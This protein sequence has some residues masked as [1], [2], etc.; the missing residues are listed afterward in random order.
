MADCPKCGGGAW[1]AEEELVQ[2]LENS[3]PVKVIIKATYQCKACSERFS[4]IV[5]ENLDVRKREVG[6]EPAQSDP[7]EGLK[8]F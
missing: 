3:D 4:R 1:L 2:V 8:F 7:A 6:S 5:N